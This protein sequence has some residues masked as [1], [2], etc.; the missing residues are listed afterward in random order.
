MPNPISD[1]AKA[2]LANYKLPHG[3]M[4]DTDPAELREKQQNI[5]EYANAMKQPAAQAP[6]ALRFAQP[7]DLMNQGQYGSQP[8]EQRI[9]VSKFQQKLPSQQTGFAGVGK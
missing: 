8:G 4:N 7:V 3:Q 5:D 1:K 9:D 6:A 2:F